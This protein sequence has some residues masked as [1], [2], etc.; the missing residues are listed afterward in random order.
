MVV[1]GTWHMVSV[2]VAPVAFSEVLSVFNKKRRHYF[3][4]LRIGASS[5]TARCAHCTMFGVT[6]SR[7]CHVVLRGAIQIRLLTLRFPVLPGGAF[8]IVLLVLLF[9]EGE[10][11]GFVCAKSR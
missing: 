4:R 8:W 5:L 9:F 2:R 1:Y 6:T 10:E 11:E 3:N 7:P